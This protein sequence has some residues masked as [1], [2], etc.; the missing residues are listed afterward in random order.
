MHSQIFMYNCNDISYRCPSIYIWFIMCFVISEW[1]VGDSFNCSRDSYQRGPSS[2]GIQYS[3]AAQ[4]PSGAPLPA[5][6]PSV[7]GKI[8]P[9][10]NTNFIYFFCKNVTL[11]TSFIQIFH[12]DRRIRMSILPLFHRECACPLLKSFRKYSVHPLTWTCCVCSIIF[13]W[14]YTHLLTPM[15]AIRH[16]AF[17]SFCILVRGLTTAVDGWLFECIKKYK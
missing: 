3:A 6:L 11:I 14:L 17:T 16:Q 2:A 7:P 10:S 4:S 12:S 9:S 8:P 15:C 13:C 5:N 1:S